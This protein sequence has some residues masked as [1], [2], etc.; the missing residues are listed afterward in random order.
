M[1]CDAMNEAEVRARLRKIEALFARPGS[2]G[3][4]LAAEA[5]SARIRA[6]LAAFEESEKTIEMKF[7]L[8]DAWS[9]QL[10]LA[11]SRRYGLTPYR[12]PRQRR[13]TLMLKV[14][15]RFVDE[16]LW[17]EF[18]QLNRVLVD[19]LSQVTERIIR[20]EVFAQTA[21]AEEIDEP[22]RLPG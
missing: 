20:E 19:Y 10:F 5:A 17:P 18:K 9:R 21:E 8:T 3:E 1:R 12:Y 13:T 2:A 22:K 16:T 7:S 11:L 4:R 6:R 15:E 14:P